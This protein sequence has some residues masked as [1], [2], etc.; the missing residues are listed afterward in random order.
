MLSDK[1]LKSLDVGRVLD[2]LITLQKKT[3]D[4]VSID[5]DA[6]DD[7]ISVYADLAIGRSKQVASSGQDAN[8]KYRVY[9]IRHRTDIDESMRV[10]DGRSYWMIES[11]FPVDRERLYDELTCYRYTPEYERGE[12]S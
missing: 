10:K 3:I 7:Y 4:D 12:T 6:Y 8:R 1:K 2:H 5:L 9:V 11:I